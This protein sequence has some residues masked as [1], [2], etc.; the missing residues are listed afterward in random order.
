MELSPEKV[1]ELKQIVDEQLSVNNI[2]G[3]IDDAILEVMQDCNLEDIGTERRVFDDLKRKGIIE[4]ILDRLQL[5]S[6]NETHVAEVSSKPKPPPQSVGRYIYFQILQG[7][8][9][10][11]HLDVPANS[12]E[13]FFKIHIHFRQQRLY[14]KCVPVSCEPDFSEG[15]VLD[16]RSCQE[17]PSGLMSMETLLSLCDPIH[18]ILT[19]HDSDGECTLI[20]SHA[21][22]WRNALAV[23]EVPHIKALE[24]MGVGTECKVHAGVL[25]VQVQVLPTHQI[26]S[27]S[28]KVIEAQ[29]HLEK[30]RCSE[31]DRLFLT[32]AKQW[33]K[34]YVQIRDSHKTRPVKIFAQDES[35]VNRVVCSYVQPLQGGR[36]I[37]SPRMA[38]RFVSSFSCEKASYIGTGAK[39]DQWQSLHAFLCVKK[40]DHEDHS[41]LLCSLLLGFGLDAFVCMGLRTNN[42]LCSWVVMRYCDD[43]TVFFW[44]PITGKRYPHLRVN[45][46]DPPTIKQ[47]ATTHPFKVV[48]C[49]YNHKCFYANTQPLDCVETVDFTFENPVLWKQMNSDSISSVTGAMH[50]NICTPLPPLSQPTL[51]GASMAKNLETKLKILIAEHRKDIDLMTEWDNKLSYLLGQSLVSYETEKSCGL[52]NVGNNDFQDAIKRAVPEGNTFKGFPIQVLHCNAKKVF[53]SCIKSAVCSGIIECRGDELRLALRCYVTVF[54]DDLVATW[55]MVACRYRSIL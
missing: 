44:D 21:F 29:L 32:Y 26:M 14:S 33:W 4:E 3:Q 13:S 10:L 34:E 43:S 24:L 15:F 9:F 51:N 30:Q 2:A 45:P 22:E 35:G 50:P 28:P 5:Q 46:N 42:M 39:V 6:D 31:R 41:N 17:Q 47:P 55:V 19:R 38:V 40:G 27:I 20:S 48:G 54:P 1:V 36:L 16:L 7:K 53:K 37:N 25:E 12:T 23:D 52:P 8:A 18:I 49:A 11:E